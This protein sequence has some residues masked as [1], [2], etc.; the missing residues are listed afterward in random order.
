MGGA[1]VTADVVC[2]GK[3]GRGTEGHTRAR[4]QQRLAQ[5]STSYTFAFSHLLHCIC[6]LDPPFEPLSPLGTTPRSDVTA[7]AKMLPAAISGSV[8]EFIVGFFLV[9]SHL[10]ISHFEFRRLLTPDGIP[11]APFRQPFPQTLRSESLLPSLFP[12]K[13][14]SSSQN[15]DFLPGKSQQKAYN[16]ISKPLSGSATFIL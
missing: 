8:S 14:L 6:P 13:G 4:R 16:P 11:H 1:G 12:L 7:S 3:P 2:A 5:S 9:R 10:D 15:A